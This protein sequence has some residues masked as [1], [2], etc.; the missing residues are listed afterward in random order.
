MLNVTGGVYTTLY[1]N[2]KPICVSHQLYG[3]KDGYIEKEGVMN[4]NA[5]HSQ[6]SAHEGHD[7]KNVDPTM[8]HITDTSNCQDFASLEVGD[9]LSVS[10]VY[11]STAHAQ[12]RGMHGHAG[13]GPVMGIHPV[14]LSR[15]RHLKRRQSSAN[16][17]NRCIL[18]RIYSLFLPCI[19]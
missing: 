19:F 15:I 2:D 10:A 13:Y 9:I 11:N 5:D 16:K 8:F 7:P 3:T 18:R 6:A 4:M 17:L 14:S 1:I 12:N